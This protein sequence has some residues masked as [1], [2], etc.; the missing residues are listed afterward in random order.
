MTLQSPKLV[1]RSC[2]V[3]P[4]REPLNLVTVKLIALVTLGQAVQ[5]VS[6]VLH[7]AESVYADF[8][9]RRRLKNQ[10]HS[11]PSRDHISPSMVA[12]TLWN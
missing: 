3:S 5:M 12:E 7:T 8:D 6:D 2:L 10:V 11:D 9:E 1:K 4:S